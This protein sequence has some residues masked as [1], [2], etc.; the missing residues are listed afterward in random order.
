M[1]GWEGLGDELE[2]ASAPP[3]KG[4]W[5]CDETSSG[6]EITTPYIE[7]A[8]GLHGDWNWLLAHFDLDPE[9]FEVENN[10]VRISKWGQ[11]ARA[12]SGDR[13]HI[14]LYSYRARFRRVTAQADAVDIEAAI[15]RVRKWKPIRRTPGRGLG[16]PSTFFLGW[17]DWQLGKDGTDA[18]IQRVLDSFDQ[19]TARIK[20]LRSI[21]RNVESLAIWNMG[22]PDE[23][24]AEN[25]ASQTFTV[26]L[27]QRQQFNLALDLWCQGMRVLAPQFHDV[28]FGSLLC[29]HGQFNRR[30]DKQITSDSDNAGGYLAETLQRVL[31]G[32]D[33]MSHVRWSIPG[34]EM[35]MLT[36]MSGVP[37]ALAH[38]H[39]APSGSA[40]ETEFLRGQSIRLLREH[41]KEPRLWMTA[42]RHHYAITDMGPWTR[43]QMPSLDSGSKWYTDTS[44]HWSTP[45]TFSCLVGE[46]EAAGGPLSGMGTG[47]SDEFVFVPK[48]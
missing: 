30:G 7:N 36:H 38:G 35:S 2:N 32:S 20:E 5:H 12:K 11:S 48:A 25:Y 1:T 18:T 14:W 9:V 47:F 33:D 27:T 19:A 23:A 41:G 21:G 26:E 8:E 42:H 34:S 4:R 3:E 40:A 6:A 28:E 37:V 45:G 43:I 44:G 24:C 31:S 39:K 22:D 16:T 13:D 15:E 46:H 10:S 17:A 29:N